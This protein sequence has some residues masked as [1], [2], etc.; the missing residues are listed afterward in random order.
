MGPLLHEDKSEDHKYFAPYWNGRTWQAMSEG[1]QNSEQREA[2]LEYAYASA[3]HWREVGTIVHKQ[4]AAWLLARAWTLL[5][6]P[7]QALHYAVRCAEL[8]DQAENDLADFDK[9]YALE[10]LARAFALQGDKEQAEHY[11]NHA[12]TLGESIA[13]E[14]DRNLFMNDLQCAPWFGVIRL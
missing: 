6:E 2:L 9:P 4:R 8:T 10:A 14:D 5:Q 1:I 7:K 11:Y 12:F 3:A 13:S